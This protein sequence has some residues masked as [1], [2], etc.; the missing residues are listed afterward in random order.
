MNPTPEKATI[1]VTTKGAAGLLGGVQLYI[2]R[3]ASSGPRYCL[4][5]LLFLLVGWIPTIV[6]IGLRAFC[7]RLIIRMTGVAA[8]EPNVRLRFADHIRLGR[9]V[10]LDQGVYLHAC[11]QGITIGENTF[12][13]HG[14]VLHVYNF[15]ALPHAFIRIGRDSLIGELNVLRGQ[16]GITIGDRVYTAPLVQLLAVNHVYQDP[17]RPMIEQGITA[18]GIVVEDDVWIGA[19]AIITDGVHIGKGAVVAAGAVVTQNVPAHTVVGGVPARVLKTITG[20]EATP[21]DRAIFL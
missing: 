10:Y 11:P 21:T 13:M 5:Q 7:Y 18:E 9:N 19:G 17:N 16:G 8:I 12:I 3:Q 20:N 15:R 14:A 6:G 2:A 4:E 1:G